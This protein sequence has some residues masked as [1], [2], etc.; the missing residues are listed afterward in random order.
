MWEPVTR[1]AESGLLGAEGKDR[2]LLFPLS[3]HVILFATVSFGNGIFAIIILIA[4]HRNQV[5]R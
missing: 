2:E 5:F 4:S 3:K 1:R